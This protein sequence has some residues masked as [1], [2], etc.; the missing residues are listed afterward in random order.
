MFLWGWI[1]HG[2]V[3]LVTIMIFARQ[4]L[5]RPEYQSLDAPQGEEQ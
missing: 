2:F 4:C 3:V 5:A 1:G